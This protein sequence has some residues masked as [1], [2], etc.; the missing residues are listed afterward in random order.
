MDPVEQ[1]LTAYNRRDLEGFLAA[2]APDVVFEDG[3]GATVLH[4]HDGMRA[5]YGPLFC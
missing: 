1:Q 3:T 5:L 4:G 2:Y